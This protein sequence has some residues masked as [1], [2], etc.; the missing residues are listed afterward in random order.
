M[1]A[2]FVISWTVAALVIV[3]TMCV[4]LYAVLTRGLSLWWDSIQFWFTFRSWPTSD[5]RLKELQKDQFILEKLC[6]YALALHNANER[7]A[8]VLSTIK[9]GGLKY[10]EAIKQL[11]HTEREQKRQLGRFDRARAIAKHCGFDVPAYFSDYLSERMQE[12]ILRGHG[13][14]TA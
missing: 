1:D 14:I 3:I 2:R 13:N 4:F 9:R 6:S 12:A 5:N 11:A 10:K 8:R 7:Q